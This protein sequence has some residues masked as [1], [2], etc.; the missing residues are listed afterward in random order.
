MKN[1]SLRIHLAWAVF[2]GITLTCISVAAAKSGLPTD[3][4]ESIVI[5]MII[6]TPSF[7]QDGDIPARHT[8]DGLNISPM[9]EW[10]GAPNCTKSLA[11]IV[12]DPEAPIQIR[13]E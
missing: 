4:K 5:P 8:C 6:T 12:D 11:L 1:A 2:L 13:P 7:K 10:S 3:N 9:L